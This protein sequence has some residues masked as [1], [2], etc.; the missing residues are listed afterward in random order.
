L[1]VSRPYMLLE[2]QGLTS[3]E[4]G[5]AWDFE[6]GTL[7]FEQHRAGDF[8][9]EHDVLTSDNTIRWERNAESTET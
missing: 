4:L 9:G 8:A 7:N 5:A 1:E 2:V 6:H 3:R